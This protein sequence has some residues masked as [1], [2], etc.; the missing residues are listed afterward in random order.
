MNEER[1]KR[2]S[3]LFKALMHPA[4]VAILVQLRDGEQCVCH[5]EAILGYRQ[6]YVSQQ[7]AVL[8]KVGLVASRRD[9][10]QIFYRILK[11]EIFTLL[12]LASTIMGEPAPQPVYPVPKC[13]CP[14]CLSLV[15]S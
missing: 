12:E 2:Q 7:L 14:K 8:R 13:V 9:G 6:A 5:L 11:P 3:K 4:R 1:F 15:E 10:W